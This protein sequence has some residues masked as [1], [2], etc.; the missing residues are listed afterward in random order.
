MW[1][2]YNTL[3]SSFQFLTD[4]LWFCDN[5]QSCK[6][7]NILVAIS[8]PWFSVNILRCQFYRVHVGVQSPN[9]VTTTR[10]VLRRFNDFLKLFNEVSPAIFFMLNQEV[11]HLECM[12]QN[13]RYDISL[14]HYYGNKWHAPWINNLFGGLLYCYWLFSPA[15][16]GISQEKSSPCSTQGA[17]AFE[18]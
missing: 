4:T 11:H 10:G 7:F 1:C 16:E 15:Q 13:C 6:Y 8:L 2:K 3:W 9:G 5:H 17:V 14:E 18:K 12:L